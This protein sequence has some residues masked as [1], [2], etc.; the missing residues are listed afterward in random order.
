MNER[1]EVSAWQPLSSFVFYL[2]LGLRVDLEFVSLAD[3][4]L[5]ALYLP[6]G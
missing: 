4:R 6:L 5:H 1:R 2:S 3:G